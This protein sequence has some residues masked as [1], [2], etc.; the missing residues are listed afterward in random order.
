MH[1]WILIRQNVWI[2]VP[3]FIQ[4]N[5]WTKLKQFMTR[6]QKMV[7]LQTS[8]ETRSAD[9][10]LYFSDQYKLKCLKEKRQKKQN[11]QVKCILTPKV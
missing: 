8:V 7:N 4:C 3:L 5:E 1:S 11:K 2:N 10:L 6:E 9:S